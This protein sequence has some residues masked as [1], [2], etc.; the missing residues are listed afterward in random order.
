MACLPTGTARMDPQD[1]EQSS[2]HKEQVRAQFG[3]AAEGYVASPGHASGEDLAQYVAWAEGGPEKTALDVATGGGHTALALAPLYGRVVATDLTEQM[4]TAA[5]ASI[6][7]QGVTNVEFQRADAEA[8]PFPGASFELVSCRIAP[9]H[10]SHIVR[11]IAEVARVLKPGGIF[12]LEDTAAPEDA[13]VADFFNHAEQLRDPTH[14]RSLSVREWLEMVAGAGLVVE[15][16]RLFPK[17]HSFGPW[18]ERARTPEPVRA[19]VAAMFREA[20]PAAR[21]ALGIRVENGEVVSYTDQ[22][23]VLKARRG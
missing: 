18:L 11:F 6:R 20:S 14:V 23:L 19:A 22:K 8:L 17:T 7:S 13:S 4:L 1:Q 10:F 16:H 21:A 2:T 9:H 5:E 15:A 12:L 3:A